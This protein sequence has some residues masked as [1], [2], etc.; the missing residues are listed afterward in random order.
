[1]V[2]VQGIKTLSR[3]LKCDTCPSSSYSYFLLS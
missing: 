2:A 3:D 1:V